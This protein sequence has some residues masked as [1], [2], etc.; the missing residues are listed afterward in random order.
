MEDSEGSANGR[1]KMLPQTLVLDHV[2]PATRLLEK[3]RQM[4][5]VQEALEAQKLDFNRKEEVFKRRE[6]ALK[7]KDLEL[8]ESLIRFS[9]FLQENDSKRARA[10]KKAADEIKARLQKE[11][12]I[13]QLTDVLEELKA[14]KERILEVLEKNMRYQQYLESVL[15]VADEYQEVSDLLLRHATLSATNAD[16]KDHQRRCSELA[17]KVRTELQIYVKQKTD[18]IL[19]LN[20][21]VAKLKTELEGYEAEALVQEAKKDSSLQIASQRTLEYG[22]VVLSADNIFNRCRSKSSIGHPAESNPLHQ[23]DVIGN[24]VSDLGVIIKQ[25][26]LEQAKRT[27]TRTEE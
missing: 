18:E 6:E 3:R 8:Q 21:Q 15:E 11:K 24:F 9:K 14:E 23:L 12:E 13:E 2:S 17:E 25:Y 10:E 4:F 7:L 1:T 5:E 27:Q 20:N 22:Q 19:N 26:R 16:L